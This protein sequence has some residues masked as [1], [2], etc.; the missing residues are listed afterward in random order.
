MDSED[1]LSV[2]KRMH[3]SSHR[4]PEIHPQV[5]GTAF[6]PMLSH[7]VV[8]LRGIQGPGLQV[9]ASQ[10][11]IRHLFLKPFQL[12][13]QQLRVIGRLTVADQ[14]AGNAQIQVWT[15][16]FPRDGKR[17]ESLQGWAETQLLK[18]A[19]PG[20]AENPHAFLKL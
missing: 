19:S 13:L 6:L 16:S 2:K 1:H 11:F 4:D 7:P 5:N 10:D 14:G 12:E 8:S 9:A 17:E 3:R 18:A 20:W 15:V